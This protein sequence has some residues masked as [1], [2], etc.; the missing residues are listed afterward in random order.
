[1]TMAASTCRFTEPDQ[2]QAAVRGGG[3][4]YSILGRGAFGADLTTIDV[5]R[6]KLQ[7]AHETLPRLAVSGVPAGKVAILLWPHNGRLPVV[8][9]VQVEMGELLCIGSGVES[10]HRTTNVNDFASL[11]L[12]APAL[13]DAA[14]DLTSQEFDVASARLLRP[15]EY[16]LERL[17]L[18]VQSAHRASETMPQVLSSPEATK[19][20]EGTL[21]QATIACLT[22]HD[23]LEKRETTKW[24][25][26]VI[27]KKLEE[28][29]EANLDSPLRVLELCR[30]TGLP[31]RALRKVCQEQMGVSPTRFLALRRLHM[32]RQALLRADPHSTTVTEIAT[33]YGVWELGRFAVAYKSLFGE[34]PSVTL[35]R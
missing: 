5:G 17:H 10:H 30:I 2:F 33:R 31:E 26:A 28:V 8:R 25:H 29:L 14:H 15:P 24:R 3:C 12:D 27:A 1:M 16:L 4:S 20:F 13:A 22:H 9:G 35:R 7:Y 23:T 11:T 6:V 32:A 18:L 19:G 21:L 34:S